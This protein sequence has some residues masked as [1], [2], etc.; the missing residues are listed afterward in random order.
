M[1]KNF[2]SNPSI[3]LLPDERIILRANP[4]WLFL[5]L[6]LIE[7][8]VFFLLY[9]FFACPFLGIIYRGGESACFLVSLFV[10]FFLSAVLYL[11]WRLNRLYL[12]NLRLIK[13]RGIIGKTFMAI[14]LH[15]IED[16]TCS[17][18]IWGRIFGYGNLVIESA[19][20]YGKMVFEELPTPRKIKLMIESQIFYSNLNADRSA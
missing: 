2:Q 20:T 13:E 17:F 14:R 18:G 9:F 11:D 3:F 6:P 8:V 5:A 1:V 12:T 4:H 19:G 10:L 16:I 15:N 7:I